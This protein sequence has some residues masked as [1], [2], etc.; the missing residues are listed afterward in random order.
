MMDG[1]LS[2]SR[3]G[4]RELKIAEVDVARTVREIHAE[5]C[6]SRS[7]VPPTL[8]MGSLPSVHGDP[9]LLWTLFNNLLSNAFKFTQ[10]VEN[11]RVGVGGYVQGAEV[12]YY[13]EDNGI[14]FDMRHVSKL[15]GVFE[16]L[17][18]G[19]SQDGHGIGLAVV[20]RIAAR[21]GGSVRAEGV[22]GKGATFF[23]TLPIDPRPTDRGEAAGAS[24]IP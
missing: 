10:G 16:R 21:H 15:F 11:P 2:F 13:V 3:V 1:L 7:G 22:P 17:P 18:S 6:V 14:G 5:L 4:R 9:T 23:V 19:H 24:R 20:K 8:S 12:V